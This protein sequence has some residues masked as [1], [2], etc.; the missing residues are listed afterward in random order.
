VTLTASADTD[1]VFLGWSGAGCLET[2]P[3][4]FTAGGDVTVLANFGRNRSLLVTKSGAGAGTVTSSPGG[5]SCGTDC[6]E[7]YV[8]GTVVRLTATPASQAQF[9]GW[10]G[11]GC[12][13]TGP[14]V[15]TINAAALVDARFDRTCG[16]VGQ[17]CCAT[18]PACDSGSG[19]LSGTCTTCP[20][21]PV[22]TTR[23]TTNDSDG[24]NCGGVNNIHIYPAQC[25]PGT[26]HERCQAVDINP[27][28]P[29]DGT[30]CSFV[31]WLAPSNPGDCGC[32]VR[33][34]APGGFP[35][36]ARV[37]CQI[38]ITETTNTPPHPDGCPL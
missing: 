36:Q 11:G 16:R 6:S 2:G 21:A 20:A 22:T 27:Q 30:S 1:S 37:N 3:C 23:F 18:G 9:T 29:G 26:H 32:Q 34:I 25:D 28:Q 15:L 14:C 35:C 17:Q 5:V 12:S 13:G 38:T 8:A 4:T 10:T 24:S 7:E 33:M 31:D 19:C